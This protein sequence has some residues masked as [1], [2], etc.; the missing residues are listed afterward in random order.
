[1]QKSSFL[2]AKEMLLFFSIYH[3]FS[4]IDKSRRKKSISIVLSA[5]GLAAAAAKSCR[6]PNLKI[7]PA[8]GRWDF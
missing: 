2:L 7:P 1:M 6:G 5:L 8:V 4:N 3:K